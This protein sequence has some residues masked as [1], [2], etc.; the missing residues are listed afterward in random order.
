VV[1]LYPGPTKDGRFDGILVEGNITQANLTGPLA[2]VPLSALIDNMMAGKTYVNV[3]TTQNP[4]GEI[5]GQ[6]MPAVAPSS[7]TFSISG[8]KISNA[9]GS[10]VQGWNI[11]LMNST[12]STSMLTDAN[13]SYKFMNLA[14]GTYN[15]T[16]GMMAG[17]TNVSP[18][19]QQVTIAGGDMMNVNFT[20]QP[21]APS[22][23][24]TSF[25]L[26]PDMSVVLKGT[27]IN[28][29]ITALNGSLPQPLFNGMANITIA[30]NNANA[31]SAPMNTTFVNGNAT[32]RVNSSLAQFV[33]VTITNETITGSTKVEFADMVISL[34][35]GY[36]L[37]SIP[38]FAN[39]SDIATALQLVQNNGVQTF[40]PATKNFT[41][42]TD[43]L[44]LYGYWINVTADNQKLGFIADTTVVIVP[45]TR[46][47]FEGWNLIGVSA[48]R[49]ETGSFITPNATFADLR[50]GDMPSQWLYSRLVSFDE[51]TGRFT[52]STAGVDLALDSPPLA[53][54]HGY[55]L[56]IK[57]VPNANKNNVP[58][59]GKLW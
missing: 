45:P 37:I 28:I 2:G 23:V 44:P 50:N 1:I 11:T 55:W 42:P 35:M 36:N 7:A 16:E 47:L 20:N 10:G 4:A 46:N 39:P 6:I 25:V 51:A 54:G 8:F 15:V 26:T 22:A 48:S 59:A 29:N 31:V 52:T 53:L 18:M 56:F 40:D 5:R 38:A 12:M 49:N 30:A 33:N 41:T 13:G 58:W 34:N 9:T 43:L 24:V 19:S 21:V 17:W 3:H 57:S 27:T 14:N 32:I